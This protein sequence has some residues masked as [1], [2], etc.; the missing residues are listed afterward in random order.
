MFCYKFIG[1]SKINGD[2]SYTSSVDY[3]LST[4]KYIYEYTTENEGGKSEKKEGVQKLKTLPNIET[5]E[6]F[7]LEIAGQNL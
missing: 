7:S 2:A 6:L 1:G 5:H 4:G 3:N